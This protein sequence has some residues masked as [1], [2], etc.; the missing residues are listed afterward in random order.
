[1]TV[2][3]E[4]MAKISEGARLAGF[5]PYIEQEVAKMERMVE[6]KAYL[7]IMKG[8][9]TPEM[10]LNYWL[11]KK[12]YHSLLTRFEQKVKIGQL[13]GNRLGVELNMP[14]TISSEDLPL[15]R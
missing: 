6:N 7:H 14:D 8:T 12:A 10:A 13:A 3:P 9:L 2:A 11:E 1:M 5:L 15:P 4:E